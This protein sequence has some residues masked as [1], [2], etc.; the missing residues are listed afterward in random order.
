[1][2]FDS[3]ESSEMKSIHPRPQAFHMR[4]IFHIAKQYFTNPKGID[5]IEKNR[6]LKP[7]SGFFLVR[8]AGL[9]PARA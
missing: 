6:T 4:S 9:E 8:E 3:G 7:K 2:K 5:F 1:M